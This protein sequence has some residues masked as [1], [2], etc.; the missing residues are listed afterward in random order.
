M[1]FKISARIF[2]AHLLNKQLTHPKSNI[3]HL[4]ANFAAFPNVARIHTQNFPS[5]YK[6]PI[7]ILAHIKK[8]SQIH[9]NSFSRCVAARA[10]L[11]SLYFTYIYY[12]TR[13][14]VASFY[15]PHICVLMF[16]RVFFVYEA[17][18]S[19]GG[20][21]I[22][23]SRRY[24]CAPLYI[25]LFNGD[26]RK[27]SKLKYYIGKLVVSKLEM[28]TRLKYICI[29]KDIC[30]IRRTAGVEYRMNFV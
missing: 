18:E 14:M 4:L 29:K 23:S 20:A 3:S 7:Y 6:N 11:S 16:A 27:W 25:I 21:V 26:V 30:A 22:V 12:M 15:I 2:K 5:I 19:A 17:S 9:L 10:Y 24:V 8:K 1:S 13:M 28:Y